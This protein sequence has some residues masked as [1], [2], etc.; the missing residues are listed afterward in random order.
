[1]EKFDYDGDYESIR[2]LGK[3]IQENKYIGLGVY[4]SMVIHW[5]KKFIL[6]KSVFD[7]MHVRQLEEAAKVAA[8]DSIVVVTMEDGVA[9]IWLCSKSNVKLKSKIE[10]H[11]AKKKAFGQKTEKQKT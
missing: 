9:H 3:N 6:R 8:T 7:R 11:I 2:V 10:K 5:P 4:Q 1:M